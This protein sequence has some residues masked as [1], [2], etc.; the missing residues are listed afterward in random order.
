VALGIAF[1]AKPKVVAEAPFAIN[2]GGLDKAL[3]FLATK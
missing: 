2:D 1:H 3:D